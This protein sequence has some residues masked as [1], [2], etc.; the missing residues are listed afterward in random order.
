MRKRKS[1]K[2]NQRPFPLWFFEVIAETYK[3]KWIFMIETT[4]KQSLVKKVG[5]LVICFEILWVSIVYRQSVL[6][7]I[8]QLSRQ[9]QKSWPKVGQ[10]VFFIKKLL[11]FSSLQNVYQCEIKLIQ[12]RMKHFDNWWMSIENL[13]FR[14]KVG[15]TRLTRKVDCMTGTSKMKT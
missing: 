9:S 2:A 3:D 5:L 14:G 10:S 11:I 8:S 1:T 13:P 15:F 7:Q 12:S 4:P 6:F